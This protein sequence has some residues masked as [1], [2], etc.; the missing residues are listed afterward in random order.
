MDKFDKIIKEAVESYEAPYDA[1]VWAN[2]SGQLG[3]KGGAMKW[4]IGSAAAVVLITGAVYIAQDDTQNDINN[5]LTQNETPTQ[6]ESNGNILPEHQS[7]ADNNNASENSN[8]TNTDHLATDGIHSSDNTTQSSSENNNTSAN[9][10][11]NSSQDNTASDETQGNHHVVNPDDN[12]QVIEHHVVTSKVNARFDVSNT[13]AC[14]GTAFLFTPEDMNQ[15]ALYVWD[16]GDG[17]FSAAKMSEHVYAEAGTY[18]VTLAMKDGRTNKTLAK[19]STEITVNPTPA[20]AFTWEKSNELIPTVTFINLTESAETWNWDIKG[21][22]T[23]TENSFEYTFRKKGAYV[24]SLSATN[25]YGCTS[26]TEKNI[27]IKNDYNLLAPTAFTPNG[28]NMNDYFIPEALRLMDVDFTMVIY[29]K[30]GKLMYQTNEVNLPW[31]GTN[32]TDNSPAEEGAYVWKVQFK[33]SNG[34]LEL[35]EG[36]VI[37]TR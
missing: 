4:I 13:N 15:S 12:Q 14:A 3:N 18:T 34:E 26:T 28:D 21:L 11:A 2:V 30:A 25:E 19:T 10:N 29:D 16:F 36:Q 33:N 35:Y 9:H 20:V 17:S 31:D 6:P 5:T 22:K 27:E 37:I 7:D 8:G 24:V 32:V 23:S 1:Q